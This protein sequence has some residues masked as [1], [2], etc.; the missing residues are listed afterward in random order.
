[1]AIKKILSVITLQK[2]SWNFLTKQLMNLET[3]H[4][5]RYLKKIILMQIK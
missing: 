1:M 3:I 5:L 4:H 2:I